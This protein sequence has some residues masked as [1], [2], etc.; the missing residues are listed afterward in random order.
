MDR[1]A[2]IELALHNERTEMGFYRNEARRSKNPLAR[3]MFD[4]LARD[5]QEHMTR[6]QDLHRKLLSEGRW[7]EEVPLRV[8]DTDIRQTLDRVAHLDG[9]AADHDDDDA[10]AIERAIAFEERGEK[11]Y[12]ELADACEN[13]Q[14]KEFFAFL[15]GIEREHRLSLVDSLAYLKDPRAWLEQHEKIG[16][17]GA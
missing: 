13:P 2:S 12:R 4:N 3:A 9:S 17:D 14:E 16:L 11:F 1:M 6:I 15:S 8:Q 10:R 5:E 7:P